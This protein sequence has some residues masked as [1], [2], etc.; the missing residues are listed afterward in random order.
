MKTDKLKEEFRLTPLYK[1]FLDCFKIGD[2]IGN[3]WGKFYTIKKHYT[4]SSIDIDK[5]KVWDFIQENYIS[6]DKV[7][8]L[9][10]KEIESFGEDDDGYNNAIYIFNNS[11]DEVLK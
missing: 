2:Q 11:I 4:G 7:E 9:K 8:G 1:K 3:N 6:K 10:M 5:N